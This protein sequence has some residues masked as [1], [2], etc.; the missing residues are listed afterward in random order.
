MGSYH[1][2][3]R[4]SGEKAK[5]QGEVTELENILYALNQPHP[6][7]VNGEKGTN[8]RR[9]RK[10][11]LIGPEDWAGSASGTGEWEEEGLRA[12][13]QELCQ[14]SPSVARL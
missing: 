4:S 9:V 10:S 12:G 1:K 8:Q 11:D 13:D 7:W 14:V 2:G 6:C 3:L 5:W